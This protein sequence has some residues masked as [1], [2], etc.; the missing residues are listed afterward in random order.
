MFSRHSSVTGSVWSRGWLYWCDNQ[1]LL[2]ISLAES[3]LVGGG[4]ATLAELYNN[5]HVAAL[6]VVLD[7]L[8][9]L[10]LPL[11]LTTDGA[12]L[13]VRHQTAGGGVVRD[14]ST[15]VTL[16]VTSISISLG[17]LKMTE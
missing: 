13:G 10:S 12:G 3:D 16:P 4:V 6:L 17:Q 15:I 2:T 7:N 9:L 1:F 11:L 8:V 5:P 14:H